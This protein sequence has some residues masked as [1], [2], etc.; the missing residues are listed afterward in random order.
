MSKIKF[1][2]YFLLI[3]VNNIR[4][5]LFCFNFIR[6]ENIFKLFNVEVLEE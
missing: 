5:F 6:P 3:N 4:F 2:N 1:P